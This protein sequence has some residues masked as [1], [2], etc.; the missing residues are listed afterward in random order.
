MTEE[1]K[2][3]LAAARAANAA[4]S[5]PH[6]VVVQAA[7]APAAETAL[8]PEQLPPA[9]ALH[10]LALLL[11]A[12]VLGACTAVVI[13]PAWL[14]GLAA[15]LLGP[16]PQA[17]WHL[18]RASAFVAYG[19]LWLAML[20]GLLITSRTARLWPGGPVAFDLHQHASLLGLAFALFHGL[21]LLG[22]AYI[23]FSLSAVVVPFASDYA[24]LWVGLGQL[25]FYLLA[26]VGLSFYVRQRIGRKAWRAL[27][28]ASFAVFVLALLHGI[29]SG[30][31]SSAGWAAAFYWVSGG[32][33]LFLTVYRILVS[34]GQRKPQRAAR[35]GQTQSAAEVQA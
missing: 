21:I 19:L 7:A 9:M 25:S 20:L 11:L 31:D 28:L 33:I 30:S 4:K 16:E 12:V 24:P 26:L 8:D 15:S 29:G 5:R 3:R 35:V 14:P 32:S 23:G 22:D 17:Y 10:T 18:A 27:H 6:P 34:L 13:L 2:A 1:K